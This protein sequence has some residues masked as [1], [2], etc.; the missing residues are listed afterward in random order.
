[1]HSLEKETIKKVVTIKVR[2]VVILGEEIIM[3]GAEG[4]LGC[5]YYFSH[6]WWL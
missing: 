2:I 6:G 1:M 5:W 3:G 4:I